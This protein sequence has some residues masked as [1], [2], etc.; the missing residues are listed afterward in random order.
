[1]QCVVSELAPGT[2]R[3]S[4]P[5]ATDHVSNVSE[6]E[7]TVGRFIA[8]LLNCFV[9]RQRIQNGAKVPKTVLHMSVAVLAGDRYRLFL[10][11]EASA[12]ATNA[13]LKTQ[14]TD[15]GKIILYGIQNTVLNAAEGSCS[16]L[17]L[18]PPFEHSQA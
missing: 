4:K 11:T 5:E 14:A 1:M 6:H 12:T 10:Y 18:L 3:D 13:L 9:L 17:R 2:G 15:S 8:W 16:K 7:V